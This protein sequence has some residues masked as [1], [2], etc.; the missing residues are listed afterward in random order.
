M[1]IVSK[2]EKET[3]QIAKD[4]AKSLKSKESGA[5]I[6]GLYGDLGAGKT[7]FMKSI[8][9]ALG[10]EETIQS[11]TFVIIKIF[12]PASSADKLQP[13]IFSKLIHIDA[14]RIEDEKEMLTLGWDSISKNKENIIF[15]EWPERISKIIG[16][17]IKINFDH[18]KSEN[19]RVIEIQNEE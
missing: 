18:G 2:S 17:H 13:V 8:A 4:F 6:V 3:A 12:N 7:T 11:P 9:S 10:V 19:E 16:D 5:T 15:V 1:K 14:Y